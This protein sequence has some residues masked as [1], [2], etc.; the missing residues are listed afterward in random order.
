MEI[1]KNFVSGQDLDKDKEALIKSLASYIISLEHC[2]LCNYDKVYTAL[3]YAYDNYLI[4]LVY[5]ILTDESYRVYL[6]D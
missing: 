6:E 4:L 1:V 2:K 5:K 3:S